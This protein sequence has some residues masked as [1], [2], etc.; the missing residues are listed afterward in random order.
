MKRDVDCIILWHEYSDAE[1]LL[2]FSTTR[3]LGDMNHLT[4][5]L[6]GAA[7]LCKANRERGRKYVVASQIIPVAS[8]PSAQ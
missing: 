2:G 7:R 5:Q 6:Q 1:K 4:E 3:F 8:L